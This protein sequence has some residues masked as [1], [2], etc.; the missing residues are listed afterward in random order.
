MS[1]ITLQE[2]EITLSLNVPNVVPSTNVKGRMNGTI[3]VLALNES[4]LMGRQEK[5]HAGHIKG[6]R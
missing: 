1:V 3:T 6:E 5:V 2:P 4:I